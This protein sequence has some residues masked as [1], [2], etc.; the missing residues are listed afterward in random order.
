VRSWR[1]L[2]ATVALLAAVA[3]ACTGDG[4]EIVIGVVGPASGPLAEIGNA[5]RRGAELA[6]RDLNR[7]GGVDGRTVRIEFRDDAEA[8]R[9]PEILRD[10]ALGKDAAA[11][12][13]PENLAAVATPSGPLREA[14][15]A[16]L[17]IVPE[18]DLGPSAFRLSPSAEDQAAVLARWLVEVRRF[19]RIAIASTDDPAGEA[20]SRAMAAALQAAGRPAVAARSF[21]PGLPDPS[22]VVA[23]LRESRAGALV[24][25]AGP[26][27]A[28]RLLRAVR[29]A[30]WAVQVAGPLSLFDPD[31][32]S[33]A[34]T[35]T[36]DSA[37]VL[38]HR[39]N[40]FT[41]E[42]I[43]WFLG[44]SEA[45]GVLTIPK[46]LTLIPA[47]SYLDMLAYDA[48]KVVAE[49]VR[50]AGSADAG[51]VRAALEDGTE[52]PG[53]FAS[54]RFTPDDHEAF[55]AESLWIARLSNLAFVYDADPRS[56]R[57]TEI[58]F[59]KVQVSAYY[60]PQEFLRSERGRRIQRRILEQV[61]TDPENVSFFRPYRPPRPPPGP[62]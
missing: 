8:F 53:V 5:S 28:A 59:Y 19:G 6:A 47:L 34:G 12:I 4:D 39:E 49:A 29:D 10:L 21:P 35:A 48:V 62:L 17:S 24:V 43:E 25:W 27:D 13:G 45:S 14:E 41:P 57:E 61:L 52:V 60:V 36:D 16:F 50:R 32:R 11:I 20:G 38:P 2:L 54:Y 9:L 3:P 26:D 31:Y 37:F 58:A 30:R 7:V 22:A 44:Y 18:G 42:L 23:A 51:E 33:L 1:A 15:T 55:G 40:W 56:D 46:Q